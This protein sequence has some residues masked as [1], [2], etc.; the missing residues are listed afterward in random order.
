MPWFSLLAQ[1]VWWTSSLTS[2]LQWALKV[3]L[4]P[5]SSSQWWRWISFSLPITKVIIDRTS[6]NCGG[7]NSCPLG[8]TGEE[9]KQV[10]KKHI[11]IGPEFDHIG[12]LCHSLTHSLTPSCLVNLIDVTLVK[13]RCQLKTCWG[14]FCCWCRL[15]GSC[16]QQFVADLEAEVWL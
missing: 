10:S 1:G 9:G 12:Y 8:K 7:D 6:D 2:G 4:S 5:Y 11:F 16:W 3:L 14:C 15:W 13:W